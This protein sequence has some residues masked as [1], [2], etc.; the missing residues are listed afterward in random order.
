MARNMSAALGGGVALVVVAA[1][2]GGHAV[3]QRAQLPETGQATEALTVETAPAVDAA[4]ADRAATD[5]AAADVAV[6]VEAADAAPEAEPTPAI[7]SAPDPAQ[8]PIFDEVRVEADGLSVVAGRGPANSEVTVRLDGLEIARAPTDGAGNFAALLDVP[9]SDLPQV[10]TVEGQGAD[11]LLPGPEK[12]IVAPAG[13]TSQDV[14]ALA[15]GTPVP[16]EGVSTGSVGTDTAERPTASASNAADVEGEP[17]DETVRADVTANAVVEPD[18][19]PTVTTELTDAVA[20]ETARSAPSAPQADQ[21]ATETDRSPPAIPDAPVLRTTPE[22]STT[23]AA[24]ADTPDLASASPSTSPDTP[25]EIVTAAAL[26]PEAPQP[27]TAPRVFR[28][29]P[30]GISVEGGAVPDVAETL[31]LDA[32]AYDDEGEVQLA[33]RAAGDTNLQVYL[34][35]RPVQQVRVAEGGAWASPL[36]DID[37]GVYTLRIDAIDRSGAVVGRIETPFERTA[38]ELAAAARESG[39][40]AITVQPGFTLWAISEGYFGDGVQYVQI[41]EAN[42][43]LIRNPDLIYPGQVITLPE[44]AAAQN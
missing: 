1:A 21:T 2:I 17:T 27:P 10:L 15:T 3:W 39:V 4:K 19:A 7:P 5:P 25:P 22:R 43:G 6:P 28:A 38:P 36:P 20:P 41:F 32:I 16:V 24:T 44:E 37:V 30:G 40:A 29:G 12:L 13:P 34:D 9:T 23:A 31:G 14:A 33:G 42:R 18:T 35:N 11:G 26:A 8:G